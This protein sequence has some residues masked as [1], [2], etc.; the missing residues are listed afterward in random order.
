MPFEVIHFRGVEG[1]LKKKKMHKEVN[2]ILAYIESAL[3]ERFYRGTI[4][5]QALDE[6]GWRDNGNLTILEGRRYQFKG[7]RNRIAIEANLSVYEW[8]L[9][10]L[11]RLQVGCDKGLVD[12]GILLL[13]GYRSDKSPL[14][15][16][17]E[18]VRSEVEA[19]YP[20]ISLPVSVVLLD[21]GAPQCVET[22]KEDKN[23]VNVVSKEKEVAHA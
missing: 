13:N 11:F 9:E 16:Q 15:E 7:L 18:L 1:I 3:Q 21:L 5:K 23:V 12:A 14:G 8:I 19:L 2:E 22:G 20:T 4:L 17:V 10:G 6:M